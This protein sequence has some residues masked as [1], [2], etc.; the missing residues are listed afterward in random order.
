MPVREEFNRNRVTESLRPYVKTKLYLS[1]LLKETNEPELNH[2][3]SVVGKVSLIAIAE[4]RY[5][6]KSRGI[7]R[8]EIET[9]DGSRQA[10]ERFNGIGLRGGTI[11][12]GKNNGACK[13]QK[14]ACSGN[15]VSISL[16]LRRK[17]HLTHR[18]GYRS[19]G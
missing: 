16:V 13:D 4:G 1:S 3:F 5:S 19:G 7:A 9:E 11:A 18:A 14:P 10:K 17:I 12:V 15:T 8:V 6:R 2:H